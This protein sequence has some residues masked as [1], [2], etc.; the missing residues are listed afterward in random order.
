MSLTAFSQSWIARIDFPAIER[1]DAVAFTIGNKVY[2]GTGLTPWFTSLNDFY[3]FDLISETWDIVAPMPLGEE[4]QY[5]VGFTDG[6]YGYVFGGINGSI[7]LNDL[8]RFEPGA[9]FWQEMTSLPD[10]G[11]SGSTGFTINDTLYVIGGKTSTQNAVADVWAYSVVHDTWTKKADLPYTVWRANAASVDSLGYLAFGMTSQGAYPKKL[12]KYTPTED[13][14]TFLADYPQNGLT[15]GTLVSS[16]NSLLSLGG[17]DSL[18]NYSN[19]LFRYNIDSDTWSQLSALPAAPRKGGLA[20]IKEHWFYYTTGITANNTRLKETWRCQNAFVDL[21]EYTQSNWAVYPNPIVDELNIRTLERTSSAQPL[22]ITIINSQGKHCL[23]KNF[24][25]PD[26]IIN[27]ENLVPG[28]YT[29]HVKKGGVMSTFKLSK[30][31]R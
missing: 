16:Q 6:L 9:G 26:I 8:W 15:H 1:D 23:T 18:N 25:G 27:V 21:N 28:I 20:F 22:S 13:S 5:A 24:S 10:S 30:S 7:Y 3:S 14:W 29:L 4:R 19:N 2:C 11:R 12:L 17:K 31:Q